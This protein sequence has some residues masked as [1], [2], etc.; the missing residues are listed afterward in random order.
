M[1]IL[2]IGEVLWDVFHDQEFLGG[3]ALNFAIN[4]RR[5][6]HSCMLI[7]A[8]G[9]DERGRMARKIMRD[10]R[11]TLDMLLEVQDRPTGIAEVETD[12]NGEPRFTIKRPAAYDS[13][14][15]TED[16]LVCL[17]DIDFDWLYFGTLMQTEPRIEAIT[18]QLANLSPRIRCFYDVNL[19]TGHWNFPLVKRLS[20]IASV[21]KLNE[22]EARILSEL[23]GTP[24]RDFSLEGFCSGWAS[25]HNLNLVCVTRGSEGCYI[26]NRGASLEVAGY[27][28]AVHDT[29]GAGDAFSAALLHGLDLSWPIL[30]TAQFANSLGSLVASRAGATPNWSVDECF[31]EFHVREE[32]ARDD[33]TE[34]E[35]ATPETQ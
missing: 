27:P 33:R 5:L 35:L 7:T 8:I 1:K 14:V 24:C 30:R 6:G 22:E 25:Q 31:A 16:M 4:C 19:R 23:D 13:V 28:T 9:M 34:C 3:A 11:L 32:L 21:I 20:S 12:S 29:V 18:T 10:S 26:F 17:G 15:L 2:S